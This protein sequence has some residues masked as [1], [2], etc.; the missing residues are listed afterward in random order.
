MNIQY[1]YYFVVLSEVKNF[2]IAAKQLYITPSTL[3]KA[4]L[5]LE[6]NFEQKL[7]IRS[8]KFEGLTSAGE[9]LFENSKN[10][11][12]NIDVLKSKIREVSNDV[13]YGEIKIHSLFYYSV[14][15]LPHFLLHIKEKY[16]KIIFHIH[17]NNQSKE[18]L[19]LENKIDI[20]FTTEKPDQNKFAY[21][22]GLEFKNVIVSSKNKKC[23]W[24]N[25]EYIVP[26]N[27]KNID[28]N[29]SSDGWDNHYKRKEIMIVETAFEALNICESG[30][31]AAFLPYEIA[32]KS[33]QS[34]KLYIVSEP[35]FDFSMKTYVIYSDKYKYL[36]SLKTIIDELE[37]YL[38]NSNLT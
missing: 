8:N 31:G 5:Q 14:D 34:G 30:L 12:S 7:V 27:N 10:I 1:L 11:L 21:F 26:F 38:K 22:E 36:F 17:D 4:I 16:P 23:N 19:I 18:K 29:S 35:P 32:K 33:I 24:D 6:K 15:I 37:I 25:L 28:I 20:A 9:I 2:N 13:P 3:S